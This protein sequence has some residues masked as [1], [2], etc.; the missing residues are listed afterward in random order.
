MEKTSAD[1]GK[2]A[3]NDDV[4]QW[5]QTILRAKTTLIKPYSKVKGNFP[6]LLFKNDFT[7]I[8]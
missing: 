6:S 3:L 5:G 1:A 8:F 4:Q 2:T 7:S